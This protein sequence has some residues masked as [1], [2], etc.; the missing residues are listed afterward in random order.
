[1]VKLD[2]WYKPKGYDP[3]FIRTL[4]LSGLFNSWSDYGFSV[5]TEPP[6]KLSRSGYHLVVIGTDL[7]KPSAPAVPAEHQASPN[8][9]LGIYNLQYVKDTGRLGKAVGQLLASGY[10]TSAQ[11]QTLLQSLALLAQGYDKLHQALVYMPRDA[12]RR[13][14]EEA[15]AKK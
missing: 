10:A 4:D 7:P 6:G 15:A 1:M 9:L 3:H 2:L 8:T 11:S 13:S 12:L 14:D 5:V